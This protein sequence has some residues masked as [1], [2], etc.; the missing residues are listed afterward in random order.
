MRGTVTDA[1]WNPR[2]AHQE[3]SSRVA[4]RSRDAH[5]V[6]EIRCR[7]SE[8]QAPQTR[9]MG[10]PQMPLAADAPDVGFDH[11]DTY[12]HDEEPLDDAAVAAAELP[13]RWLFHTEQLRAWESTARTKVVVAG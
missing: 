8:R 11:Y 10:N 5:D 13:T 3:R 7:P 12:W 6:R 4:R 1:R 9:F 2:L